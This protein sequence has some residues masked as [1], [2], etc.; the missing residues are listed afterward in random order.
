[1]TSPGHERAWIKGMCSSLQDASASHI[2]LNILQKKPL[3][4]CYYNLSLGKLQV[5]KSEE[6]FRFYLFL[7]VLPATLGPLCSFGGNTKPSA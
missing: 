5:F 7:P 1:M 3:F 2:G 6:V 4:L